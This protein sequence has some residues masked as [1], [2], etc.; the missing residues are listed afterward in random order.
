ME[1]FEETKGQIPDTIRFR[2]AGDKEVRAHKGPKPISEV[3]SEPI[4]W[5]WEPYIP[6]GRISMLGGDPGAGKSFITAALA[7]ALSRGD[8]L[9]GKEGQLEPMNTLMLSVEDDPADTIKPRLMN[10][11]ADQRRIFISEEDIVLDK[12]G[13]SAI[14]TMVKVTKAKLVII[15]PIV[16]FLGPK[17]DMNRANE[18][19]HI[20]KGIAKI[21]KKFNIAILIV[22]HNRKE[23]TNGA[24]GKAIYSGMGSIDFTA[25]VRSEMAITQGKN[26]MRF[27]NHIK[28]NSGKKG[29]SLTYDIVEQADGSGLFKWGGFTTWPPNTSITKSVIATRFRDEKKIIIWL[30]EILTQMPEGEL[31]NEIFTKG[32]LVGFSR[33]KLEHAKKGTAISEKRGDSW[34]WRLDPNSKVVI[35]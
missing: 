13:L 20:M 21:A 8:P 10:L 19:R 35:E 26:G 7:S 6:L 4:E 27:L 34:Y 15:D 23:G 3:I 22:R 24:S 25:S 5:L 32:A 2:T 29:N 14:E 1:Q 33:T 30:R 31:A 18:V 11:Q 12:D 17:M 28:T 9:P 16:A